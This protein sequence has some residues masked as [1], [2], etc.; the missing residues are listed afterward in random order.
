MLHRRALMTRDRLQG[1]VGGINLQRGM[2]AIL[3][4]DY[5]YVVAEPLGTNDM[6]RGGVFPDELRSHG[7]VT[8]Q[9]ISRG[10]MPKVFVEAF[11]ATRE[12]ATARIR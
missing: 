7:G 8:L 5:G 3:V 9:H 10:G 11:D 2:I 6:E 4:E 12:S 1:T